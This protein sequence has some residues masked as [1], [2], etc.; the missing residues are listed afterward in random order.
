MADPIYELQV[1]IVQRLRADAGVAALIGTKIY[2]NPPT[3]DAGEVAPSLFPYVSIGAS[4]MTADDADC[5]YGHDVIFQLDVW[6][7]DPP[8]KQMR[9]IANAV[10]QALRGWEPTLSEN[11]LVY[12]DYES[13]N[14]IKDGDINH[15]AIRYTALIEQP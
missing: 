12:F 14:Y 13:T 11:A 6:S 7:I 8:Q 15:A 4:S 3:N 1:A 9:D 5:I 10:R 2:D